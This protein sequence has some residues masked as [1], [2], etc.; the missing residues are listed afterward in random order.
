MIVSEYNK[1]KSSKENSQ[2][3]VNEKI[4]YGYFLLYD[5]NHK[6]IGIVQLEVPRNVYLQGLSTSYHYFMIV[7]I[8]GFVVMLLSWFLLKK[9]VIDRIIYIND[10]INEIN[11]NNNFNKVI[12]DA[13]KDE[14]GNMVNTINN[15]M[16]IITYSQ[17]RLHYLATHDSLTKLPNREYFYNLIENEIIH[18]KISHKKFAIMFLDI[19]K[20]KEVND[21]YGHAVGDKLI[22]Y[23]T[24][25]IK[26]MIRSIDVLGRQ[27]GDE[28][29][30]YLKNIRD[31][32]YAIVFAERIIDAT[33]RPFKINNF[34]IVIS[35][36]IGISIY[37]DN[38][39][40]IEE[41]LKKADESMYK[42]KA[43]LGN[44][45]ELYNS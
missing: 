5:I 32:E 24:K 35:F 15:M 7:V 27:S 21:T 8:L 44:S 18:A 10:Q 12:H 39:N 40:N 45:Y 19:D 13:G 43:K 34:N 36:S 23:A 9:L 11:I 28:F 37:P 29:L 16:K 2:L 6:A 4:A 14:L 42:S 31:I 1:L 20:F 17:E 30:L 41:L 25:R 33:S 38:G 26:R 22:K 3:T